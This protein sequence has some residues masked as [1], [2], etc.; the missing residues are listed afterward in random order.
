MRESRDKRAAWSAAVLPVTFLALCLAAAPAGAVILAG[1]VTDDEGNA[2]T[3]V[4]L[5]FEDATTGVRLPLD[6]R[7]NDFG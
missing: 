3:S 2:V 1:Q 6:T 7:T 4:D 5:D